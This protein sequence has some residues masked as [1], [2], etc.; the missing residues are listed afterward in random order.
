MQCGT[1]HDNP[2][3]MSM[4]ISCVLWEEPVGSTSCVMWEEEKLVESY[5]LCN[6]EESVGSMSCVL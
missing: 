1:A 2:K 6:V 5:Q 3:Q 4:L